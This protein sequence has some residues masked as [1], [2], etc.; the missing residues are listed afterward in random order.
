M[1]SGRKRHQNGIN[2]EEVCKGGV[3]GGRGTSQARK[4]VVIKDKGA[5]MSMFLG[6]WPIGLG[7]GSVVLGTDQRN[8]S[9]ELPGAS[10]LSRKVQETLRLSL[11]QCFKLA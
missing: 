10:L 7:S 9:L 4:N 6:P 2:K 11:V 5:G 3:R 8:M 1:A